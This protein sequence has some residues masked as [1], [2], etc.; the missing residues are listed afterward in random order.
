MNEVSV[1]N[2]LVMIERYRAQLA[3]VCMTWSYRPHPCPSPRW[4]GNCCRLVRHSNS[5]G[6]P[7][8]SRGGVGVGSL[9]LS[10]PKFI[11]L[12]YK[13]LII[14]FLTEKW[15]VWMKSDF[16]FYKEI[17]K[18]GENNIKMWLF[19]KYTNVLCVLSEEI[20][21]FVPRTIEIHYG[22]RH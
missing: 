7:L 21:N 19:T 14:R 9:S 8:P 4:E 18:S 20:C 13:F 6:F 16:T 22:Q 12:H 5:V 1:D 3:L 17:Q 2:K 15:R 11:T 10:L